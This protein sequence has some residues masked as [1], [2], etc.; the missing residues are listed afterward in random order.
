MWDDGIGSIF[1]I[2]NKS[3]WKPKIQKCQFYF[4]WFLEGDSVTLL[5]DETSL[6]HTNG[7][8]LPNYCWNDVIHCDLSV[9]YYALTLS[10]KFW[11]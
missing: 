2:S 7:F 4:I 11:S 8:S 6:D 10:W 9:Y 5:Q 1:A 3:L